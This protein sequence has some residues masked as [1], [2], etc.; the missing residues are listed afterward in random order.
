M[1]TL[2]SNVVNCFG[3]KEG[4]FAPARE[5]PL[6]CLLGQNS[7]EIFRGFCSSQASAPSTLVAREYKDG[8][9]GVLRRKQFQGIKMLECPED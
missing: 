4:K 8:Q 9:S 6:A 5:T 1:K 7:F 3:W 2:F